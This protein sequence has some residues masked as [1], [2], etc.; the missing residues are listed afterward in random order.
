MGWPRGSARHDGR[1]PLQV[2]GDMGVVDLVKRHHLWSHLLVQN[3]VVVVVQE[4]VSKWAKGDWGQQIELKKK[5]T[6]LIIATIILIT[7]T[8]HCLHQLPENLP[9]LIVKT[10]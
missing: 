9:P 10:K 2:L 3:D 6:F 5:K 1:L 4:H 8:D 7:T